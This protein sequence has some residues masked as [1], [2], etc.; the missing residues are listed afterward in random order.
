MLETSNWARKYTS[1]FSFRNYTFSSQVHPNFADVSISCK[2]SAIF[3]QNNT[4]IQGNSANELV[5]GGLELAM[6]NFNL[7]F[8]TFYS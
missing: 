1:I 4:F 5:T 2:K 7:H 3:G 8:Q 6:L